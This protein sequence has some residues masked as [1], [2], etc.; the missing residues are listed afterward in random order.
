MKN[1]VWRNIDSK[2]IPFSFP[3]YLLSPKE[4]GKIVSEINTYYQR[5]KDKR[6]GAHIS[7]DLEGRTCWYF[8]ENHGYNDYNIFMVK[9]Y[10]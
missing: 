6:F 2:G 10:D 8:F 7:Q 5:Y 9:Y 1:R 4:Y 3:T